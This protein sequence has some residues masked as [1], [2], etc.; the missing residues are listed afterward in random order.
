M[1]P[2]VYAITK[3]SKWIGGVLSAIIVAQATIGIY[4][5]TRLALVP[6]KLLRL[7]AHFGSLSDKMCS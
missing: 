7:F 6:G 5:T 4:F 2:R 3:R 1:K